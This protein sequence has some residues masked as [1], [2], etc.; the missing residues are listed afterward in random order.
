LVCR[1]GS[2]RLYT[3]GSGRG[4]R[5]RN[6][7]GR[8]GDSIF[9]A[10]WGQD[11]VRPG[12]F[13]DEKAAVAKMV[14]APAPNS[15]PDWRNAHGNKNQPTRDDENKTFEPRPKISI[16]LFARCNMY[17]GCAQPWD[18]ESLR[19]PGFHQGAVPKAHKQARLLAVC[20]AILRVFLNH[21]RCVF[22]QWH[23]SGASK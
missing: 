6:G 21:F 4:L 17:P 23:A 14:R 20:G 15:P 18:K 5:G 22:F 13:F 19:A 10:H 12:E 9:E 2:V 1:D 3:S 8:I 7:F 16:Q 11:Q